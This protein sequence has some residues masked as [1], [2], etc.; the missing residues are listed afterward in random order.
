MPVTGD[1]WAAALRPAS[2]R[3][4]QCQAAIQPAA[5]A[6]GQRPVLPVTGDN[7]IQARQALLRRPVMP[8][9]PEQPHFASPATAVLD[10]RLQLNRHT[11]CKPETGVAGDTGDL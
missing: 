6:A 11:S 3:C 1:A 4:S 9:T 7:N 10:A 8:V 2:N 5:Q